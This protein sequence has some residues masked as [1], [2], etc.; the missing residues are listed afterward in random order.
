MLSLEALY[1]L[2]RE[3]PQVLMLALLAL[4]SLS[5]FPSPLWLLFDTKSN[6]VSQ[7]NN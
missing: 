3:G 4:Y 1:S 5:Y 7:E 2:S 6:F